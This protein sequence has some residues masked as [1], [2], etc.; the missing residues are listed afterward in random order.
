MCSASYIGDVRHLSGAKKDRIE[1]LSQDGRDHVGPAAKFVTKPIDQA[2]SP[3]ETPELVA[4]LCH[5][6]PNSNRSSLCDKLIVASGKHQPR[7][8]QL[9]HSLALAPSAQASIVGRVDARR[10]LCGL[11][12]R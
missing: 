10:T 4:M 3:P 7:T 8:R 6:R 11:G 9:R 12:C 2:N 1:K 5:E